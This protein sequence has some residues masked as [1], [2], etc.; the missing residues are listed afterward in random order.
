LRMAIDDPI[1]NHPIQSAIRNPQCNRQ[2]SVCS[3][4][5]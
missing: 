2:S 5:Y 4:Q 1:A 3:R